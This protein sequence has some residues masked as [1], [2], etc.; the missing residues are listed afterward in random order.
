[1]VILVIVLHKRKHLQ[2]KR[3]QLAAHLANLLRGVKNRGP[4]PKVLRHSPHRLLPR[5]R[6]VPLHQRPARSH[7]LRDRL[8]AHHVFPGLQRLADDGRLRQDRQADDH[9]GDVVS[10]EQRV[11]GFVVACWCVMVDIHWLGR[12]GGEQ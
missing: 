9:G 8:L 11:E 4:E 3:S 2:V 12:R 10:S 7:V 5:H 1:M 6:V